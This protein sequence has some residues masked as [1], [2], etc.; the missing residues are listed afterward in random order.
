MEFE[1]LR[2][3]P[4]MQSVY[5]T[6]YTRYDTRPRFGAADSPPDVSR[7]GLGIRTASSLGRSGPLSDSD[8]EAL[9][10]TMTAR[11]RGLGCGHTAPTVRK[12]GS[13]YS[14][15]V[16]PRMATREYH[17]EPLFLSPQQQ[18]EAMVSKRLEYEGD[19]R[20]TIYQSD[21]VS[22]D[23]QRTQRRE[24]FTNT[25]IGREIPGTLSLQASDELRLLGPRVQYGGSG[26]GSGGRTRTLGGGY[27]PTHTAF[28]ASS[29][30]FSSDAYG[31]VRATAPFITSTSIGLGAASPL[32]LLNE[33]KFQTAVRSMPISQGPSI[34]TTPPDYIPPSVDMAKSGYTRSIGP[35]PILQDA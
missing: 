30:S 23:D 29:D 22:P 24:F 4:K 17:P 25:A 18:T 19:I 35:N 5:T 9:V 6:S 12:E 3:G 28:A 32:T 33:P 2:I 21:Y 26:R 20:S 14:K 34:F 11:H 10:G 7:R 27:P 8:R 13:G 15:N 1:Y 16:A 31:K